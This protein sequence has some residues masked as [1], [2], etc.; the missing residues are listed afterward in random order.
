[1]VVT[2][3]NYKK[4][5]LDFHG[6]CISSSQLQV[7]GA[8]GSN[9]LRNGWLLLGFGDSR[10]KTPAKIHK[11]TTSKT[12]RWISIM[13]IYIYMYTYIYISNSCSYNIYIYISNSIIYMIWYLIHIS[14]QLHPHILDFQW[15]FVFAFQKKTASFGFLE[16]QEG[17]AKKVLKDDGWII[18]VLVGPTVYVGPS[19]QGN[20][21]TPL[22]HTLGNPPSQLWKESIYSLL[23][24]VQGCVP[25]VCWNNLRIYFSDCFIL[26]MAQKSG[27]LTSWGW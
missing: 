6:I 25:K 24:K 21:N 9:S 13:Y 8:S 12:L 22:E 19:I 20:Y 17:V 27:K 2:K 18:G 11:K 5:W 4:W 15:M 10:K 7:P 14:I 3:P 1:M 16:F 26:L 23:V